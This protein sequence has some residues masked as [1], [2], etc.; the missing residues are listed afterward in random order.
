MR[1]V[2]AG[3]DRRRRGRAAVLGVILAAAAL[4]ADA[5][6]LYLDRLDAPGPQPERLASDGTHLWVGDYITGLIYR[7]DPARPESTRAY[8]SP[9]P[10]VEGLTWDGTHLWSA[11][12]STGLIYR[13]AVG[14]TVLAVTR[15]FAAP[16]AGDPV[17]L[18]WDGEALWLTTWNPPILYRL[19]PA[20]GAVL[21]EQ[22]VKWDGGSLYPAHAF[23]PEDLAWDGEA[24][25]M[26]DWWTRKVY[27]INPDTFELLDTRDAGG[28]RSLG[29]AF[30]KGYLWN[31]DTET[32]PSLF[33][34]DVTDGTP[35]R[36]VTWGRLKRWEDGRTAP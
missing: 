2:R 12:W 25:W 30:H 1:S 20:A 26:T 22:P 21:V 5:G 16:G 9:G 36:R 24:L 6:G 10:H 33:R 34:L 28:N 27:R 7:V 4:S 14:D 3:D 11:D 17:G 15:S 35:V 32:P 29:L 31:G 19:D 18:A 23:F 13:L 8:A